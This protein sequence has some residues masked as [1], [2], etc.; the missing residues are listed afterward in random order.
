MDEVSGWKELLRSGKKLEREGGVELLRNAYAI[1]ETSDKTR[2]EQYVLDMLRSADK[3]WEEKQGALLAAKVILTEKSQSEDAAS[4]E[5][6]SDVKLN[7]VVLLQHSEY[8]VRITAG[9]SVLVYT[10][11]WVKL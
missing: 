11:F 4:C 6:V 5:F 2:I 1:A 10:L 3:R 8:T 9:K 7:V